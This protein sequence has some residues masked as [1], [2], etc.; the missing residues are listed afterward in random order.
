M[1]DETEYSELDAR[2][3]LFVAGELPQP[4]ARELEA[5]AARDPAVA[6]RVKELEELLRSTEIALQ[7]ADQALRP[8]ASESAAR[9]FGRRAR[10]WHLA[11]AAAEAPSS[12]PA[13]R[14]AYP[15]WA[16]PLAS[17]AAVVLALTVWWISRE[18]DGVLPGDPP[19][20]LLVNSSTQPELD[21][22]NEAY[23]AMLTSLD[24]EDLTEAE[25]L[26]GELNTLREGI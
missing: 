26:A 15:W 25:R 17:A 16:Y 10:E 20:G 21:L 18:H 14:L 19:A 3:L 4:Q 23:Y 1:S 11:R 5:R 22:P 13:R 8:L 7:K 12:A 6:N 24:S 9:S 2:I